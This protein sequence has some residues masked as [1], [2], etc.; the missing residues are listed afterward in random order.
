MNV[1]VMVVR[2]G[3]PEDEGEYKSGNYN[4]LSRAC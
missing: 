4:N 3:E 1:E 2:P